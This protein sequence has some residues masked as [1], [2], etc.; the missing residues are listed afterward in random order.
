MGI[1]E[2]RGINI[3]L[4]ETDSGLSNK[5]SSPFILSDELKFWETLRFEQ[6]ICSD[7]LFLLICLFLS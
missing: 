2:I 7:L 1:T 5:I 6:V 4:E 3:L